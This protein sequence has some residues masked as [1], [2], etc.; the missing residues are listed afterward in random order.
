VWSLN[1]PALIEFGMALRSLAYN[2]RTPIAEA[3]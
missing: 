2:S 1:D 3:S